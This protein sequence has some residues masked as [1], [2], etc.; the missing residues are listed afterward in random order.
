MA[1]WATSSL[2]VLN[3]MAFG[4]VATGNMKAKEHDMQ[5]GMMSKRGLI[6]MSV[7]MEASIGS[8]I[9][10]VETLLVNSVVM[11]I[12]PETQKIATGRGR[13]LKK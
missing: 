6:R 4:G 10:A 12:T 11:V 9:V 13:L 2:P 8:T 7:A 5:P 1:M 3:A